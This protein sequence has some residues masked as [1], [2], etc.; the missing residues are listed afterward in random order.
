MWK[1]NAS[2]FLALLK[3]ELVVTAAF[4]VYLGIV[5]GYRGRTFHLAIIPDP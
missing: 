4:P 5:S 3:Q 1:L 2:A